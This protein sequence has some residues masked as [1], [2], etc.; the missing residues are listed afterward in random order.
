MSHHVIVTKN[1]SRDYKE[2]IEIDPFNSKNLAMLK[3]Y[4]EKNGTTYSEYALDCIKNFNKEKYE[5][6]KLVFPV[7]RGIYCNCD[8]DGISNVCVAEYETDLKKFKVYIDEKNYEIVQGLCS[9]SFN[10]LG[11]EQFMILVNSKSKD[12]ISLLIGDEFIP[13]YDEF[14]EDECIP[15]IKEKEDFSLS[16]ENSVICI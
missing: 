1:I 9:Y 15:L 10:N 6:E 5:L 14:N 2:V 16:Q 12:L 8:S 13:L 7:F 3:E 4:D 11:M